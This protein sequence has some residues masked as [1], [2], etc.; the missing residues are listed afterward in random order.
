MSNMCMNVSLSRKVENS[1]NSSLGLYARQTVTLKTQ[2]RMRN[3]VCNYEG[4][5]F[6]NSR[7][8]SKFP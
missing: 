7:R 1:F 8:T 4:K 5:V 3:A 2:S 6:D